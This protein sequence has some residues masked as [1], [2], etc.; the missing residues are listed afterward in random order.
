ML[1]DG[2]HLYIGAWLEDH[3]VWATL[4]DRDSIIYHDND[5]EVFI[6]PDGDGRDYFEIEVNALGTVFDLL[7]ERTYRAGGPARH[8]W[9]LA[10]LS[11]AV[12]VDGTLNDP[13]DIDRGWSVEM[14]IPWGALA[15]GSACTAYIPF[16]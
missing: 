8:S 9:N 11:L 10:G 5:F 4:T 14:A 15:R 1:W 13:N 6:D 16:Q 12:V 2:D 3:D 7:L